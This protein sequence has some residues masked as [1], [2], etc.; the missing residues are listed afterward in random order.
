MCMCMH[1]LGHF[2]VDSFSQVNFL[3]LLFLVNWRRKRGEG[4]YFNVF[5]GGVGWEGGGGHSHGKSPIEG[6]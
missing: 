6:R 1:M 2:R 3:F 4:G 5:F